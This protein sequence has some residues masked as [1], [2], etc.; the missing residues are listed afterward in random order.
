M[1]EFE[2]SWKKMKDESETFRRFSEELE[3]YCETIRNIR[4]ELPVYIP[5]ADTYLH[6]L[7]D[8]SSRMN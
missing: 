1:A 4:R 3:E 2:V 5:I 7:L 8:P 6:G